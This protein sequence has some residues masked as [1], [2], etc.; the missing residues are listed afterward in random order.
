MKQENLI[1]VPRVDTIGNCGRLKFVFC[2]ESAWVFFYFSVNF[3]LKKLSD[4]TQPG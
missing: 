1:E 2:I 3:V 4:F